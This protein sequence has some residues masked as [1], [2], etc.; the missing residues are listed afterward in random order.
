MFGGRPYYGTPHNSDT[1][2]WSGNGWMKIASQ[3][4]EARAAA[5]MVTDT[6]R[7]RV[8]LYGGWNRA[9]S[10]W[11]MLTDTWEWDGSRWTRMDAP[12]LP[13]AGPR[14]LPAMAF[15][16]ARSVTVLFGGAY[17]GPFMI[18]MRDDTFEWNGREW[19]QRTTTGAPSARV[20]AMAYD[21]TL[22]KILLFGGNNSQADNRNQSAARRRLW[23]RLSRRRFRNH[24]GDTRRRISRARVRLDGDPSRNVAWTSGTARE[25]SR[26]L[27]YQ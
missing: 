8:V 20:T 23:G 27:R 3:G 11:W 13:T 17:N 14:T 4:P 5:A 19:R 21:P 1:Y 26:P 2:A 10:Q 22:Q 15:D 9:G 25:S 7:N 16:A 6:R 18:P 12:G 24:T